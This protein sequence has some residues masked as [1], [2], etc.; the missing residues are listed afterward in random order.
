MLPK[1]N[2][3]PAPEITNVL[4]YGKRS[5]RAG[6]QIISLKNTLGVSRFAFIVSAG[7]DKRATVRNRIKRLLREKVHKHLGLLPHGEDVVFIA[8]TKNVS[9]YETFYP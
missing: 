3:L 9:F 6:V 2:R 8:K 5:M 1:L 4:R 7:I